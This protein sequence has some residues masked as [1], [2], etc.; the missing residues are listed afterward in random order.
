[1]RCVKALYLAYLLAFRIRSPYVQNRNG[2]YGVALRQGIH[3]KL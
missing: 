2:L 3:N 1:M